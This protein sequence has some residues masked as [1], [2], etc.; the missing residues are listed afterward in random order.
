MLKATAK[1]LS[2]SNDQGQ[3]WTRVA[4]PP[5]AAKADVAAVAISA[6]DKRVLYI[7]GPGLGV[8]RTKDG[9]R[10]WTAANQGLP[11]RRVVA[12]TTHADQADTV[13]AYVTGKGIFRSQDAGARWRLMDRGPREKILHFVH[14]NMPGSMETGWLFAATSEGVR[15]SMDCFCGW[16]KAGEL[17]GKVESVAYDPDEPQRVYAGTAKGLFVSADGGEQW[18][19]MKSPASVITAL[20][21][22][23]SGVLYAGA[24][25][26]LF[27]SRDRGETWEKVDA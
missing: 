4:L 25:G 11:N 18:T 8:F 1:T 24:N 17:V 20:T 6:G 26:S 10:S 2:Q 22:A 14:S 3:T 23:P 13:Y 16:H 19:S 7:A 5:S 27:L 12:L 21:A 15:R 9:G